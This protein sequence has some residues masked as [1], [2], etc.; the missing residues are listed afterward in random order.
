MIRLRF[1]YRVTFVLAVLLAW[2]PTLQAQTPT[3]SSISPTAAAVGSAGFTLTVFGSSFVQGA[4]LRWNG[5]NRPTT[6]FSQ[7]VVTAA[8]PAS[9]L[10]GLDTVAITV[11]NPGQ[12]SNAAVFTVYRSL[13]M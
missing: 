7:L 11:T 5:A 2:R 12:S 1:S 13:T 6:L 3:I 10:I 4:V 8:I 9:D